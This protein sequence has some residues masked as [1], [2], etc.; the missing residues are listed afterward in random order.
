MKITITNQNITNGRRDDPN[1]CPVALA[2]TET[3]GRVPTVNGMSV[4]FDGYLRYLPS[5]IQRWIEMFDAGQPV[6][7][8][9]FDLDLEG[10]YGYE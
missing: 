4:N 3:S 1:Y 6:E 9:A 5:P 8:T 2:I 7:P 10:R